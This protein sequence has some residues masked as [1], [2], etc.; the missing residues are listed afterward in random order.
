M[1]TRIVGTSFTNITQEVKNVLQ[2]TGSW[3]DD[4]R[5]FDVAIRYKIT[6]EPSNPV[7]ANALRVDAWFP[8][9]KQWLKVG[10]VSKDSID[11]FKKQH[12]N[13]FTTIGKVTVYPYLDNFKFTI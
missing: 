3:H 1:A 8:N 9:K 10:Y 6:P 11:E 12:P 7:D 5:Q 4:R 2:Q 13:A